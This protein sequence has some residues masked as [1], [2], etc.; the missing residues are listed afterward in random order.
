PWEKYLTNVD[1]VEALTGYDFFSNLPQAI[2]QCIQAGTNGNNPPLDSV[3]PTVICAPAD[4]TWHADNVTLMCTAS[5]SGSGL[6]HPTTDAS[7]SLFTS[8]DAGTENANASTNGRNICDLAGNCTTAGVTGNKIDRRAPAIVVT[9]PANGAVYQWNQVV[10]AA[11][12]CS[13]GG[14]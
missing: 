12:T 13:D 4:G 14:S 7:F 6:A 3:A 11:Y 9:T 8:V 2:Q 5:D 10:N 1:A